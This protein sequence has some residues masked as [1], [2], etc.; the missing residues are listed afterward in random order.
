[1]V[2]NIKVENPKEGILPINSKVI[3]DITRDSNPETIDCIVASNLLLKCETDI[4]SNSLNT[5]PLFSVKKEKSDEASGKFLNSQDDDV[6]YYLYLESQ[7]TFSSAQNLV[8]NG[9]S[10]WQFDLSIT[11]TLKDNTRFIIDVLY[12]NQASTATCIKDSDKISCTVDENSQSTTHLV[13]ISHTKS[14]LSTINWKS[15]SSDEGIILS[16]DNISVESG[17]YL[18]FENGNLK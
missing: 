15:L 11:E 7:L 6:F 13:K 8:F 17:K 9:N 10:K 12:N 3:I 4:T 14:V 1:M 5:L 16:K 2:F 18:S